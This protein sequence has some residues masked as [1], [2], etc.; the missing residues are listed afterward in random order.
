MK[1]VC[2]WSYDDVA[3]GKKQSVEYACVRRFVL[4]QR[5]LNMKENESTIDNMLPRNGTLQ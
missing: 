3:P 4:K 5:D 1:G 2:G